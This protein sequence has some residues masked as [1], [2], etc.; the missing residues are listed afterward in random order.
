MIAIIPARSGSKGLKNKN[1]KFF[2]GRPLIC[3]TIETAL[4]SKYISRVIVSTDS[5]KI[6]KIAKAN[7]AEIPFLR[8]K[9]LSSDKANAV[10]VYIDVLN[11]I[12]IREKIKINNF[13]VLQPTSPLRI[14]K[15]IDLAIELFNKKNAYSVISVSKFEI[16]VEWILKKKNDK[17]CKKFI[18]LKEIQNRQSAEDLFIPNGAIFVFNANYFKNK[19]KYYSKKTYGYLMPKE[20]S[21][22][23]DDILDFKLAELL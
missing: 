14:S 5:K 23:I 3:H 4:K 9:A 13:I 19:K 12:K 10:D 18:N 15:D 11:K 8:S 17:I 22:D 1:I 7:G 21:I 6:A 16:P 2:K 20:R